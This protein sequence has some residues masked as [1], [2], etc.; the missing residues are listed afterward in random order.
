MSK[1]IS[2]GI[3]IALILLTAAASVAISMSVSTNIYNKLIADLPGRAQMYSDLQE[4]DELVRKEFY[5]KIDDTV[6][7]SNI[8]GGYIN[9]L[10]DENSRY[11]TAEQYIEYKNLVN[12]DTSSI[13]VRTAKD[14]ET[15]CIRIVYVYADSPAKSSGLQSG[16][17]ITAVD[18]AAVTAENYGNMV[19]KLYGTALSS[20]NVTYTRSGQSNAVNVVKTKICQTVFY[21]AYGT[22]G[23]LRIT[24]FY[25]DTPA[26]ITKAVTALSAEGVKNLVFDVRDTQ[27]GVMQYAAEALDKLVPIASEGIGAVAKVENTAGEIIETF[28]SDANDVTMPMAVIVNS[29]TSGS[30]ELFACVLRDFGKAQLVGE[31]TAGNGTMSKTFELGDG[32]AVL[33]TV[34][35]VV[36]YKSD[37]YD[38]TG[39][40]PDYE[41][42]SD[43]RSSEE[44][45]VLAASDDAQLQYA[46]NLFTKSGSSSN[47]Q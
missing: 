3:A 30:A 46:I 36:P 24:D 39:L 5:G 11:M 17:I 10:N 4:L 32:S 14:A 7:N 12:G 37:C 19:A 27:N 35:K 45:E 6:L 16:D 40:T 43:K 1:K 22:V 21:Q 34:G 38:E 2:L 47:S 25:K 33:L 28:T 18:G 31:K 23:Y 20:V 44:F 15:G 9:G 41:V 42:L 29:K 26:E 8:A 13:G